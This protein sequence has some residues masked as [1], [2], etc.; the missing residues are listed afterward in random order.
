[1]QYINVKKLEIVIVFFIKLC[2]IL[3]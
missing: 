3:D 2:E 1:M